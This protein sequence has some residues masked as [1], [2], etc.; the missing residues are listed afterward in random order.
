MKVGLD[1]SILAAAEGIR[2][3]PLQRAAVAVIRDLPHDSVVVPAYALGELFT[4]LVRSGTRSEVEARNSCLA[5]RDSFAVP[6]LSSDIAVTATQLVG[7]RGLTYW[8]AV[9]ISTV[10]AADCRLV[11]SDT[12][13]DGFTWGTVTV[14]N[15][16]EAMR[17]PLLEAILRAGR[18]VLQQTR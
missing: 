8:E 3:A 2:G 5:W 10:A 12:L 6:A 18:D 11:L 17:H 1:T 16:F 7:V 13:P 15:P 4:V 9:V 14:T